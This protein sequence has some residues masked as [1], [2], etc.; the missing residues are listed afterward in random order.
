MND[1]T[2]EETTAVSCRTLSKDT[3]AL[4]GDGLRL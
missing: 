1:A 4:R 3:G 2:E